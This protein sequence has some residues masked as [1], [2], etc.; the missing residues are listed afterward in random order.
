MN[1]IQAAADLALKAHEGQT[2]KESKVP[3]IV[4]PI[5]VALIL[6]KYGFSEEVIAAALVHDVVEDTSVTQEELRETLG[7]A[8]AN[9][10]ASV[11]HDSSL[12]WEEKKLGYIESVRSASD[13]VKAIAT[14]DKIANAGSLLQAYEDMGSEVWGLFN[15]GKDKKIWFEEAM[16]EMLRDTWN[17]PLVQEYEE[18]VFKMKQLV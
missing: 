7:D 3:Y 13:D 11:T 1:L 15:A 8:V 4:H 18:Y 5:A 14:A 12:S 16:L 2:R 9:L 6:A 10:V 17:H